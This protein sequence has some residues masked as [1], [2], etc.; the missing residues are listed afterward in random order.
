MARFTT[1]GQ[2]CLHVAAV[3]QPFLQKKLKSDENDHAYKAA[4]DT[5][6]C[7]VDIFLHCFEKANYFLFY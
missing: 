3:T 7:F 1:N 2:K 6:S 5:S 4:S